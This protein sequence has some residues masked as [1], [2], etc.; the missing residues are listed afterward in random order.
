MSFFDLLRNKA[1]FWPE[2]SRE[3]AERALQQSG[4]RFFMV[5][6]SSQPAHLTL[7]Y[8]EAH[9]ASP[10]LHSLIRVDVTSPTP[11][12]VLVQS[13]ERHATLDALLQCF[14]L[15]PLNRDAPP[16][17]ATSSAVPV[18]VH[19]AN[20]VPKTPPD[21]PASSLAGGS[22]VRSAPKSAANQYISLPTK[23]SNVT[24][25][26]EAPAAVAAAAAAASDELLP[27]LPLLQVGES[28][29]VSPRYIPDPTPPIVRLSS[30]MDVDE[31]QLLSV[32]NDAPGD[33]LEDMLRMAEAGDGTAAAA[34]RLIEG[35][36]QSRLSPARSA[37][38]RK[39]TR[40]VELLQSLTAAD[41]FSSGVSAPG[42][43]VFDDD[44]DEETNFGDIGGQTFELGTFD[45][46]AVAAASA[47]APAGAAAPSPPA[48]LERNDTG[49]LLAA[50]LDR[51]D[52]EAARGALSRQSSVA[53]TLQQ[54]CDVT[55]SDLRERFPNA[56]T[57]RVTVHAAE[58]E[59]VPVELPAN[60][61][62][63][64]LLP[65]IVAS[66]TKAASGALAQQA[67]KLS[68]GFA[69]QV[70]HSRP[71]TDRQPSV[72]SL[73]S[74]NELP[75]H[76]A[77]R[78]QLQSSFIRW[79]NV[80]LTLNMQSVAA[81]ST[82][83]IW[84]HQEVRAPLSA[85]PLAV[86]EG[87]LSVAAVQSEVVSRV[88][89]QR[90]V[91][92]APR[93]LYAA[94]TNDFLFLFASDSLETPSVRVVNL[95]LYDVH[96]RANAPLPLVLRHLPLGAGADR[97]A[98][99]VALALSDV[100]SKGGERGTNVVSDL[101]VW[102]R[103]LAAYCGDSAQRILLGVSLEHDYLVRVYAQESSGRVHV[104]PCTH[105]VGAA[106]AIM[107]QCISHIVTHLTP[108]SL[109][110][111]FSDS[112]R[113]AD[114]AQRMDDLAHG[115][116]M[117]SFAET[118]PTFVA[119]RVLLRYL[120]LLPRPPVPATLHDELLRA[121]TDADELRAA[122]ACRTVIRELSI[123]PRL[124]LAFM[125]RF[126][127]YVSSFVTSAAPN[128]AQLHEAYI[129]VLA[130]LFSSFLI[131]PL[132][133]LSRSSRMIGGSSAPTVSSCLAFMIR[134]WRVICSN[135]AIDM[136]ETIPCTCPDE[137]PLAPA[138]RSGDSSGSSRS[139]SSSESRRGTASNASSRLSTFGSASARRPM[140]AAAP[141]AGGGNGTG[142]AASKAPPHPF[143]GAARMHGW[144]LKKKKKARAALFAPQKRYF[145]VC[146]D[147]LYFFS[148]PSAPEPLGQFSLL[149]SDVARLATAKVIGDDRSTAQRQFEL[150]C[151]G[152]TYVLAA[153]SAAECDAWVKTLQELIYNSLRM[154]RVGQSEAPSIEQLLALPDNARCAD[155]RAPLLASTAQAL[156]GVDLFVCVPCA[157]AH[158]AVGAVQCRKALDPS[159][160]DAQRLA[161]AARG[162]QRGAL[163]WEATLLSRVDRGD[164]A[165]PAGAAASH[166]ERMAFVKA[167]YVDKQFF[168]AAQLTEDDLRAAG[169]SSSA[170]LELEQQTEV[171]ARRKLARL[172]M[173]V[174]AQS[175]GLLNFDLLWAA[176]L[177]PRSPTTVSMALVAALG[178]QLDRFVHIDRTLLD[179]LRKSAHLRKQ[180]ADHASLRAAQEFLSWSERTAE[181]QRVPLADGASSFAFGGMVLTDAEQ[182]CF[183]IN[184]HTCL[185]SHLCIALFGGERPAATADW[186]R[187]LSLR[188]YGI[189]DH[190]LSANDILHG[191]L[192]GGRGVDASS[193]T[194]A[195]VAAAAA[196]DGG[197][198]TGRHAMFALELDPRVHFALPTWASDTPPLL[199]TVSA[200]TL[201]AA[202]TTATRRYLDE[203]VHFAFRRNEL[204]LPAVFDVFRNDFGA[205][206]LDDVLDFV[207]QHLSREK[208]TLL[209]FMRQ[210]SCNVILR[211][212]SG[213]SGTPKV[214][215]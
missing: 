115:L 140:A 3:S 166:A 48:P 49:A 86:L 177:P 197:A 21:S 200:E 182:R 75:A 134:H 168:N 136:A 87:W 161:M 160:T 146:N 206:S 170:E 59:S 42:E 13:G 34:R 98:A 62:L 186:N 212:D 18:P 67:S 43:D 214:V 111:L 185:V 52:L 6:P 89:E 189:A 148:Q 209:N 117:P 210:H 188:A 15:R 106:P 92:E 28:P 74:A 33:E 38:P 120:R 192:R 150:T 61:P 184:V 147:A 141:A 171:M 133:N 53:L 151:D 135:L 65:L 154:S 108:N 125:L 138:G 118:D 201:D 159:W 4:P 130:R 187:A 127:A 83:I 131:E 97:T 204:S 123:V 128:G 145:A 199:A 66:V 162:N 81:D 101:S 54:R 60:V 24:V 196:V 213:G 7:S 179:A 194:A 23:P 149:G 95:Q 103:A 211:S 157:A 2:A 16:V 25:R 31:A 79:L 9:D 104:P 165:R 129:D 156:V 17:T 8:R 180:V 207:Q 93:R 112:S 45:E 114:V 164:N 190:E 19:H 119:A 40:D 178:A 39:S 143:V 91:L 205:G 26:R 158:R 208:A 70:V 116:P 82:L 68:G 27:P 172:S 203:H 78:P 102:A 122:R 132:D 71:P 22:F 202:L 12:F 20:V 56:T 44:A 113:D 153:P 191:I 96:Y 198:A 155:C 105:R 110:A 175:K 142:A 100:G 88:H 37:D 167:K 99:D 176:A 47:P 169:D 30:R 173:R 46:V 94:L 144:L 51:G 181:L 1:Y 124:V 63:V 215:T 139:V 195:A 32:A 90:A 14:S 72:Q 41:K 57:V 69:I 58:T 77:L 76:R 50:V 137:L 36:G 64:A 35:S 73:A 55:D 109:G 174:A 126:L 85:L 11:S 80:H 183:W 84:S 107:Q 5:R 10:V 193:G 29:C 152:A 163:L 121:Q